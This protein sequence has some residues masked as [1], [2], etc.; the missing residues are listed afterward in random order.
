MEQRAFLNNIASIRKGPVL[1]KPEEKKGEFKAVSV[2]NFRE[3][4]L[5]EERLET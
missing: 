3:R 5:A 4:M 1:E 2:A